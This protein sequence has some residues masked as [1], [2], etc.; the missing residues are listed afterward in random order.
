MPKY[1]YK[2]VK[3]TKMIGVGATTYK[4]LF[5]FDLKMRG[6]RISIYAKTALAEA[7]LTEESTL[8]TDIGMTQKEYVCS[9][10]FLRNKGATASY[11][12]VPNVGTIAFINVHLPFNSKGLMES[13]L[14]NDP[15]IR[16]NDVLS[17]NV[18]FN[19]IYRN[20][21]LELEVPPDYVIYM[22]DFNYR[23]KLQTIDGDHPLTSYGRYLGAFEISGIFEE[24]GSPDIYRQFY[25]HGDELHE[26]MMKGNI[27]TFEEGVENGGPLFFPTCKLVKGRPE[28]YDVPRVERSRIASRCF[29]I[30]IVNQRA[31]SWCDRILYRTL[32]T[33]VSPL[34][35]DEYHRFDEGTV[36]KKSDHAGVIGIFSVS[37][38]D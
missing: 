20:L 23:L 11:I 33:R 34:R 29:K 2:M 26:Q 6:L 1:G 10:M 22:G 32:N 30:G 17:Q 37:P 13:V 31:P 25:L 8:I 35:C 15:M 19:D 21:V 9:S 14:K 18:C 38:H 24:R 12:R 27:Y 36:M 7:I 28:G 3:R 16:H 4:A 5:S